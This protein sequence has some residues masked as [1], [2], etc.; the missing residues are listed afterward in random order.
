MNFI[1]FN[2]AVPKG[3]KRTDKANIWWKKSKQ[4]L[5][6][7]EAWRLTGKEKEGTQKVLF[8]GNR[9]YSIQ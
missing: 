4:W 8:P 6:L 3:R 7:S 9:H 2:K 1:Y 5:S